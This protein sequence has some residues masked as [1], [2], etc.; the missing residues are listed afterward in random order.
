MVPDM[1]SL[2]KLFDFNDKQLKQKVSSDQFSSAK[3]LISLADENGVTG[4]TVRLAR[5]LE[6]SVRNTGTH[7]CGVII[8]PEP[9]LDLIPITTSQE[10]DLLVTQFDNSV[11]ESAGLLKM[12]FLGLKNLSII[13]DCV[14][15]IKEIHGIEINIDDISLEDK[16]AYEVFERI[17]WILVFLRWY[18]KVS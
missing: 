15:I 13:K 4:D 10:A 12:D 5:K 2:K 1:I 8:T 17:R 11:V 16:K 3:Q 9:L 18:E 6:G 14:K 7:A